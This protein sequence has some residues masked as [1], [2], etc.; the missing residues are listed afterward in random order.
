MASP[1]RVLLWY[2]LGKPKGEMGGIQRVALYLTD[3]FASDETLD[4]IV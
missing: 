3:T 2:E 1:P 4:A